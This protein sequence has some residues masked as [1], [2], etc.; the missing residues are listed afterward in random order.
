MRKSIRLF[1]ALSVSLAALQAMAQPLDLKPGLWV[2]ASRNLINGEDPGGARLFMSSLDSA[3]AAKVRAAMKRFGLPEGWTP[4]LSCMTMANFD[5]QAVAARA[6]EQG[7]SP[8]VKARADK[9]EFAGR[10]TRDLPQPLPGTGTRR[11]NTTVSGEVVRVS[12]GETTSR[13]RAVSDIGG[14]QTV[15]ESRDISKWVGADCE[16]PPTG[17]DPSWLSALSGQADVV[18]ESM[19]AESG[20]DP[21]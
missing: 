19:G 5:P 12:A 8:Q 6:A 16:H 1:T 2:S 15:M 4:S 18:S 13:T 9:V 10:C 11:V 20:D 7:C 17:I 14:R 3:T 21:Q